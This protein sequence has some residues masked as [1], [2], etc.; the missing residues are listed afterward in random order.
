MI[1]NKKQQTDVEKDCGEDP[2]LDSASPQLAHARRRINEF[3]AKRKDPQGV[4]RYAE[5]SYRVGDLMR[6]LPSA[7]NHGSLVLITKSSGHI[8][9]FYGID[10]DTG[11]EHLF[12][13]ENYVG[14]DE[15]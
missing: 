9:Y 11:S 3:V 4:I 10:C 1:H 6:A 13:L 15:K 2:K 5:R 12:N 14:F 8:S 7:W